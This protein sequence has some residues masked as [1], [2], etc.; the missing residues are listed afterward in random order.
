MIRICNPTFIC[1]ERKASHL[2]TPK[3]WKLLD[4][5]R[6]IAALLT[7]RVNYAKMAN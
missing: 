5:N 4:G 3:L 1:K 7:E 2:R 6:G